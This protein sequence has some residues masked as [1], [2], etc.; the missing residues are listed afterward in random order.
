M[1]RSSVVSSGVN[2]APARAM[3]EMGVVRALQR[4]G[5]RRAR[6]GAGH[7]NDARAR[8]GDRGQLALGHVEAQPAD[9]GQHRVTADQRGALGLDALGRALDALARGVDLVLALRHRA[10]ELGELLGRPAGGGVVHAMARTTSVC[11]WKPAE[12]CVRAI[13]P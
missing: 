8:R 11:W 6:A 2:G 3:I 10:E 7:V 5:D 9:R 13:S 12:P 4:Q 1:P